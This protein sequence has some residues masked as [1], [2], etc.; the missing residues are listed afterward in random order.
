MDIRKLMEEHDEAVRYV[1]FGV[2]T[3]IVSWVSYASFV[4]VGI[5]LAVSN[6]LSWFTA[7]IFAFFVNKIYVFRH[8]GS[9]SLKL[10]E[11]L[12]SFFAGRMLT[13]IIA[14]LMF[15]AL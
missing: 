3:V 8:T 6:I 14:A 4:L 7:V 5:D 10:G 9:S 2:L 1:I 12:L 15:P 13:G 11:E